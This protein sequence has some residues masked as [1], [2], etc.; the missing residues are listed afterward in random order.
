MYGSG[1]VFGIHSEY[2]SVSRKLLNTDPIRIRIHNTAPNKRCQTGIT[3]TNLCQNKLIKLTTCQCKKLVYWWHRFCPAPPPPPS[4][5]LFRFLTPNFWV[6]QLMYL[7]RDDRCHRS[8]TYWTPT[9][10]LYMQIFPRNWNDM[11]NYFRIKSRA[12]MD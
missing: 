2:G 12:A 11:Q 10:F 7:T 8:T 5:T 9:S 1:S 3:F 4:L 6:D